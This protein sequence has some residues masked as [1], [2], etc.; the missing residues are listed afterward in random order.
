VG[1]SFAIYS[2]GPGFKSCPRPGVP[3]AF[4]FLF[5]PFI[6]M[7]VYYLRLDPYSYLPYKFQ[8]SSRDVT[9]C[10]FIIWQQS[11]EEAVAYILGYDANTLGDNLVN[12]YS[13]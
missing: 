7:V 6:L 1:S 11:L 5:V 12:L 3:I 8:I 2:G 10:N 9:P 13:V 4:L